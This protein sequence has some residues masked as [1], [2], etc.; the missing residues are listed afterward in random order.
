MS[1]TCRSLNTLNT[2]LTKAFENG[3]NGKVDSGAVGDLSKSFHKADKTGPKSLRSAMKTIGD[4]AAK[5]SHTTSPVAA[6]A[7]LKQGGKKLS[8]ALV[9]FGT[10]VTKKCSAATPATT[11]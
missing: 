6:A 9:T 11:P 5:V 7:A 4:V 1:K 10:Y 2:N 8:A 3:D